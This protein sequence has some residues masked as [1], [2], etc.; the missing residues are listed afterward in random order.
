MVYLM[1]SAAY[2]KNL[3]NSL[4]L[5]LIL[6]IGYSIDEKYGKRYQDSLTQ[7]PTCKILYTIPEAT[8]EQESK[9][10]KLFEKLIVPS[11]VLEEVNTREWYWHS[12]LILE[13]FENV[14]N[15][16]E[17]DKKINEWSNIVDITLNK[18]ESIELLELIEK[19]KKIKN[20]KYKKIKSS[21]IEKLIS[22]IKNDHLEISNTSDLINLIE[23]DN[24]GITNKII[25]YL[26]LTQD[27]ISFL[28]NFENNI[29]LDKGLDL[30]YNNSLNNNISI[31]NVLD[32]LPDN[33]MTHYY[34]IGKRNLILGLR[35]SVITEDIREQKLLEK[36]IYENFK[37]NIIY[38]EEDIKNL[39]KSCYLKINKKIS[40]PDI[41]I[42]N[43]YFSIKKENNNYILL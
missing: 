10:Q 27:E 1:E 17:L 18:L 43:K 42:L 12:E 3:D 31:E 36:E 26:N 33:Y 11:S 25:K 7:N 35:P 4:N 14:N 8:I 13:F 34:L 20:P 6:K 5:F 24:P 15:K 2:R 22:S 41:N 28:N 21:E 38:K 9:I 19:I 30:L 40:N 16:N 39:L 23:L 32:F 29:N 37:I